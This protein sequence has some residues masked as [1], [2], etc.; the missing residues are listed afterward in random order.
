MGTGISLQ[1]KPTKEIGHAQNRRID[2]S[3][4]QILNRI[5]L[6]I[7]KQRVYLSYEGG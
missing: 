5:L 4:F 1:A 6:S 2:I 3:K 7:P